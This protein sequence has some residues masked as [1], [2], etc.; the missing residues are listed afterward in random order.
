MGDFSVTYRV[1]GLL[2][3]VKQLISTQSKLRASVLDELHREGIEI[4]SPTFMNSR[5][6]EVGARFLPP[7][8]AEPESIPEPE[9]LGPEELVF[10]K[11]EEAESVAELDQRI[12]AIDRALGKLEE[13]LG[14]AEETERAELERRKADLQGHREKVHTQ[15]ERAREKHR[16]NG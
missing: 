7:E 11:A 15:L 8:T 5:A 16:A 12:E 9:P 6:F 10:D 1:A 2:K 13:L 4:V 3:E 14:K